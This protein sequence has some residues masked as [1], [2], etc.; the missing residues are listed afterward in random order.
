[1]DA[2]RHVHPPVWEAI[3]RWIVERP[4]RPLVAHFKMWH[5]VGAAFVVLFFLLIVS[6]CIFAMVV[7]GPSF[8]PLLL[9]LLI[10]AFISGWTLWLYWDYK[11]SVKAFD[12]WGVVRND[13]RRFEWADFVG[14]D[15]YINLLGHMTWSYRYELIFSNG[16]AVV[17]LPKLKNRDEVLQLVTSLPGERRVVRTRL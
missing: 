3:P 7:N 2:R 17:M 5:Y 4:V 16:K 13:G 6:G 12:R 11:N 1:M 9:S 15:E 10:T 14:V 8:V